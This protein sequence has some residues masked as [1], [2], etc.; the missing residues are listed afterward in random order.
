[1]VFNT[2]HTNKNIVAKRTNSLPVAFILFVVSL[3]LL[4]C[5][6]RSKGESFS[7]LRAI[8][9]LQIHKECPDNPQ[10]K[11]CFVLWWAT[12]MDP[13]GLQRYHIWVD[14][15][16]VGAQTSTPSAEALQNSIQVEFTNSSALQ[17]SLDITEYLIDLVDRDEVVVSIWPEYSGG[18]KTDI[19]HIPV[20][21]Q[22]DIIPGVI[23]LDFFMTDSSL[24]LQWL[25]PTDVTDFYSDEFS[26]IIWGYNVLIRASD[27][28]SSDNLE[29]A[30]VLVTPPLHSDSA[31]V[32]RNARFTVLADRSITTQQVSAK[33]S[34]LEFTI[35]DSVGYIVSDS[36]FDYNN[37]TVTVTGL[38]PLSSYH[39]T[40]SAFD[41]AGNKR[42][43]PTE[44]RSLTDSIQP[45]LPTVLY[46]TTDTAFA[47]SLQYAQ[48]DSN[49][50]TYYWHRAL[51]AL[52]NPANITQGDTLTVAANC[53][54]NT[55]YQ[56]V[57]EY[58]LI[59]KQDSLIQVKKILDPLS[60]KVG[61][62]EKSDSGMVLSE[63][64][65]FLS[66]TLL[67]VV[68]G[69]ELQ[70]G[71]VAIDASGFAS[72]TLWQAIS[73]A[74]VAFDGIACPAGWVARATE[75]ADGQELYCIQDR[76]YHEDGE[77]ISNVRWEVA[78][79][80][81]KQLNLDPNLEF[82]LCTQA[83]WEGACFAGSPGTQQYGVIDR[84]DVSLEDFLR[85]DCSV[86]QGSWELSQQ[87]SSRSP[88]CVSRE[89]VRDLP[90]H[91]QEWTLGERVL[92][93]LPDS[94][95]VTDTGGVLKGTSFAKFE[96]ASLL[97]LAECGATALGFRMRP[98]YTDSVAY[99]YR[100]GNSLDTLFAVDTLRTDLYKKLLPDDFK[101]TIL[102]FTV[103]ETG[104]DNQKVVV[105]TDYLDQREIRQRG[106][107]YLQLISNG[108]IYEPADTVRALIR[109]TTRSQKSLAV[110]KDV[111]VGF[112]CCAVP[113]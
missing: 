36:A 112:R 46:Y 11:E 91:L 31:V 94:T 97:E 79:N 111:A 75:T 37:W 43:T 107:E 71:V 1:M 42:T 56:Y 4:S 26:G 15:A 72:D 8:Q 30:K 62:F 54:L 102:V 52:K 23:S 33:A 5:G 32:N 22:D 60:Q 41:L 100:N 67:Y 16:W 98:D 93:I 45:V 95:I 68:P 20:F 78:Q 44:L 92:D 3:L 74:P 70:I 2:F 7:F 17:D 87:V 47:D 86:G 106:P 59:R 51:D 61:L 50:L 80:Y 96:G 82:D 105:G 65:R 104:E 39:I 38:V 63:A 48:L 24:T 49:R 55:C 109:G 28:G 57:K 85:Q 21:M 6:E 73:V 12:P 18:D 10:K 27:A 66:D 25:R 77:F 40:L 64:G 19:R 13:E 84:L 99:L 34:E 69:E 35:M 83:Q 53:A 90:G 103:Y 14:T 9:E 113:K 108:Y 88:S 101:D 81:C 29:R 110:F 89:G 58:H 76:E